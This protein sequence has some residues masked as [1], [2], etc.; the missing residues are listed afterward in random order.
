M[1]SIQ[2]QTL[3]MSNK[4]A[5]RISVLDRLN[6]KE[7]KQKKAA[8]I[9]GLSIRQVKR[10]IRKYRK[11][12]V[13]SLVHG[14]R[15]KIGNHAVDQKVIDNVL[16]IIK[17][18][19][20]G[21]GPTLAHEKLS[22]TNEISF[23]L[24]TLR[25][26]MISSGL[27]IKKAQRKIIVHQLRERRKSFG[28]L[29]QIDGSP[30]LW[31]E[32]RG[33]YC[34]LLVFID[35]ATGK[36]LWLEFCHSETTMAY[37]RASKGY[38]KKHGKPLFFYSDRDSVFRVNAKGGEYQ[39]TQFGRAMEQLVIKIICATTPQA[40]GRVERVNQTL[41][42]RLV[43]ELRLRN[44]CTMAEANK[45]LPQ[46]IE[47][48]NRKFAV[49]PINTFNVHRP[50]TEIETTKIDQILAIEE[51]RTLSKNLTCQFEKQTYQIKT[52][53]GGYALRQARVKITKDTEDKIQIEYNGRKLDYTIF[54]DQL[55]LPQAEIVGS[56]LI[57]DKIDRLATWTPSTDHPWRKFVY[58]K[59]NNY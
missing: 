40:K 35:D 42:D 39:P 57:N 37:F 31:F 43:K 58:G 19:Y 38:F 36:L 44:I 52:K 41:Q 2:N 34:T 8:E 46:F 33:E 21:F 12:G 23:G 5:N 24:E 47:D 22:E 26:A 45:Y 17:T 1:K 32:N 51:E 28:E 10:L 30:H 48:F 4:E 50:L 54:S 14:N 29:V 3:T 49:T 18:K 11:T 20:F 55:T 7:I 6:Q 27:W 25:K 56:K 13:I 59:T 9:L 53:T 15:G 16:E